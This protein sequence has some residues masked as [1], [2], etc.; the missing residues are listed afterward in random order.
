MSNARAVPCGWCTCHPASLQEKQPC[1]LLGMEQ[2]VFSRSLPP[3]FRVPHACPEKDSEG[4]KGVEHKSSENRL[5]ELGLF[6]LGKRRSRGDLIAL[7][8]Y[9]K[10]GCGEAEVG[11]FSQATVI[12]LEMMAS[13]CTRGSSDWILGKISSQK[14]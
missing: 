2:T 5:R 14:G 8:S 4:V 6:C 12:G 10:G 7:Y 9:L 13:S 3:W 1:C 11:L